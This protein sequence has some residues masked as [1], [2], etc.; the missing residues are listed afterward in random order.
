M[1][2]FKS[3]GLTWGTAIAFIAPGFI[4]L[5]AVAY[6][7]CFA[8]KWLTAATEKDQSVGLFFFVLLGSLA[9]GI[10]VSGVR[11]LVID[12]L[13]TCAWFGRFAVRRP[14]IDWSKL[15]HKRLVVLNDLVESYYRY[16]QFY[17][18]SLVALVLLII[19]YISSL[20]TLSWSWNYIVFV[21][22]AIALG[23]S[24][25]DT[26]RKYSEGTQAFFSRFT[27]PTGG[28]DDQRKETG[29]QEEED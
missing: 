7:V 19:A 8:D 5:K 22:I 9:L 14:T 15:D 27:D 3:P 2:E 12:N 25:R 23:W 13:I 16:Y 4:S 18:N 28:H 26:F 1:A 29:S 17:A 20:N 11:A 10:A 21:V 24:S 6:H